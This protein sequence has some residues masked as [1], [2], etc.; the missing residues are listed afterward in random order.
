MPNICLNGRN[1]LG[2]VS[3]VLCLVAHPISARSEQPEPPPVEVRLSGYTLVPEQT[4][5]GLAVLDE[6]GQPVIQRVPLDDSIVKPGG[7][8]LYVIALE[9]LT[10]DPVLQMTLTA[11]VA[12]DVVLDPF[13]MTGT[14]GLIVDWAGGDNPDLF[15]PLFEEIAGEQ[16]MQAN[17]D[18][19]RMLRLSLPALPPSGQAWLEYTVTLR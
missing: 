9:N 4:A 7:L 18:A 6:V 1:W 15:L 17:L 8:V 5:D 3:I 16:V 11:P 19:L 2:R 10:D 12:P 14:E 13:S